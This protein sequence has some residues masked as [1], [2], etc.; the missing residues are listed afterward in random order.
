MNWRLWVLIGAVLAAAGVMFL[1]PAIPQDE[2]YHSFADARVFLGV[3]NGLN[4]ISNAFFLLVGILGIRF[5]FSDGAQRTGAFADPRE[6]W[7]Y[8][9]FFVGV[10]LTAFGS[11]YYH[12]NPNDHT[13]VWDRI[14][15]LYVLAKILEAADKP[16]FA[17]GH[18]VSGH[19]LK[20]FAA[21]LS[22]YWVLRMLGLRTARGVSAHG[23]E[24]AA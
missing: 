13:L 4:V 24:R 10:A 3:P 16:I 9:V 1:F 2:A 19:T 7:P 6:R 20:H 21:A 11:S 5:V 15:I 22:T 17:A 8:F 14:P 23:N 12:L 18:I